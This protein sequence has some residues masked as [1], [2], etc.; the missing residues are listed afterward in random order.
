VNA[1][2]C[3]VLTLEEERC[4]NDAGKT[5]NSHSLM[6]PVPF[7]IGDEKWSARPARPSRKSKDACC[8]D[9]DDASFTM[10]WP[11]VTDMIPIDPQP[12]LP[13][14]IA[15][16]SDEVISFS[17]TEGTKKGFEIFFFTQ[18]RRCRRG[19]DT[20][21]RRQ[22]TW[23]SFRWMLSIKCIENRHRVSRRPM[24]PQKAHHHS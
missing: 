13:Q 3:G 17:E 15:L 12:R 4:C 9:K 19:R 20:R 18:C 24:L 8:N 14:V 21:P 16:V 11:M 7:Q 23:K 2:A 10:A 5:R 1:K 22:A 6:N